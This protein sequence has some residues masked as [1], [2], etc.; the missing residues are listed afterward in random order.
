[1][2]V[3]QADLRNWFSYHPPTSAE[4]KEAYEQIRT[5]GFD[6]ASAI[7]F[8]VPVGPDQSAAIRKIREAVMTAN[9]GIACDQVGGN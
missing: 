5:A 3:T 6:M 9:A 1:M 7:L 2:P 8:Y 4:Q